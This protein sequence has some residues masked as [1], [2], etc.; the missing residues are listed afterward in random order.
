MNVLYIVNR[1]VG[2]PTGASVPLHLAANG[3]LEEGQDVSVVLAGDAT[4][5]ARPGTR[6]ELQGV[7]VPA[8]RDLFA[9]LVEHDVPVYV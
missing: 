2:D 9:K 1:G 8:L 4:D 7:A 3:S 5:L 6:E